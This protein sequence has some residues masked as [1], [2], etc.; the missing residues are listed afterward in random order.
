MTGFKNE[1]FLRNLVNNT[2]QEGNSSG[3][4]VWEQEEKNDL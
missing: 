2:N 1:F 3:K 4:E